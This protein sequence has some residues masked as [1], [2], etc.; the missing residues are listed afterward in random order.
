MPAFGIIYIVK[1]FWIIL[2]LSALD[3]FHFKF[4]FVENNFVSTKIIEDPNKFI[5]IDIFIRFYGSSYSIL[6]DE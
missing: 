3:M 1:L 6:S 4:K 2:M 5:K